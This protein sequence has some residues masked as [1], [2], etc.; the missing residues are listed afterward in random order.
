PP[1]LGDGG[2]TRRGPVIVAPRRVTNLVEFARPSLFVHGQEEGEA[3]SQRVHG[4][5]VRLRIGVVGR[6]LGEVSGARIARGGIAPSGPFDV[7]VR[8]GNFGCPLVVGGRFAARRR[9]ARGIRA[10]VSGAR[11]DARGRARRRAPTVS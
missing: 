10:R 3:F 5:E 7:F 2:R 4:I 11:R 9:C 6:V 1:V 8:V